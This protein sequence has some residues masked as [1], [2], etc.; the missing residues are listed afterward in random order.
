M[1]PGADAASSKAR[2]SNAL[3]CSSSASTRRSDRKATR[4]HSPEAS[5]VAQSAQLK[6]AATGIDAYARETGARRSKP[7][8][9][10][11]VG[12]TGLRPAPISRAGYAFLGANFHD[13]RV[14]DIA[15]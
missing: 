8:P 14:A 3:S 11:L 4:Y 12:R 13:L 9:E 1:N 5:G 2:S 10:L 6:A 7:N 15:E